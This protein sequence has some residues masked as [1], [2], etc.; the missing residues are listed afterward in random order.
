M[1]SNKDDPT[2][3]TFEYYEIFILISVTALFLFVGMLGYRI[4][5]NMKWPRSFVNSS[6][7]LSGLG[8]PSVLATSSG[9][10]FQGIYSLFSGL[11]F[12][13]ILGIIVSRIVG[14]I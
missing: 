5:G 11:F 3:R 12:V 7:I 14:V 6:L 13:V 8:A 4:Y 9:Q 2:K 10:I 1:S